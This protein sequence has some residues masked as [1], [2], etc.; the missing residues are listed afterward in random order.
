MAEWIR[1]GVCV[2]GAIGAASFVIILFLGMNNDA[3]RNNSTMSLRGLS[4]ATFG[5][6][7]IAPYAWPFCWYIILA[8][9]QQEK[10]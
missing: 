1:I 4:S 2:Y 10:P 5:L 8:S 6:A 9:P 7:L 3:F